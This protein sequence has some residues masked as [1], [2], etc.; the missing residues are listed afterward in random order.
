LLHAW[1]Y[2][3]WCIGA[4]EFVRLSLFRRRVGS[5]FVAADFAAL[6]PLDAVLAVPTPLTAHTA[7]PIARTSKVVGGDGE[8]ALARALYGYG[9]LVPRRSPS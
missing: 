2:S 7:S 9:E 8:T 1:G 5:F 4:E 3:G 6:S